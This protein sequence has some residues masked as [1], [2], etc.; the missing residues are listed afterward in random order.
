[1]K[2]VLLAAALWAALAGP[3]C[4][5]PQIEIHYAPT[6]RLDRIDISLID[7]AAT[8][9][10]IAAYVLTDWEVIDALNSA[11]ARGVAVRVIVDP[12]QHSLVD[13]MVGLE[14][15]RKRLGPL[16]HLKAYVVDDAVLKDRLGQFQPLRRAQSGQRSDRHSRSRRS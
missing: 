4:A 9:I 8:S 16:Q 5:A 2:P 10:E 6:E 1:M 15:R 12:R 7:N 14:L 11:A 3:A 13:R